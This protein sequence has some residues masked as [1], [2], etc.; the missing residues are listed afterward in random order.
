MIKFEITDLV[1]DLR[2]QNPQGTAVT[3]SFIKISEEQVMLTNSPCSNIF[4]HTYSHDF[5][6]SKALRTVALKKITK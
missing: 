3:Q 5:I 2:N 1:S 4:T 6:N